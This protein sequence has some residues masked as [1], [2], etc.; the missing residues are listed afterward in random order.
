MQ[1]IRQYMRK[2]SR[3][4]KLVL[5]LIVAILLPYGVSFGQ[6]PT[7]PARG[8]S[9]SSCAVLPFVNRTGHDDP[10][11]P[12]KAA[13]ALTLALEDSDEFLVTSTLDLERA[14]KTTDV[15]LPAS[16]VVQARLGAA[17]R[18]D[19]ILTG[20]IG[21][22]SVNARDGRARCSVEIKMFDVATEAYLD[23]ALATATTAP[24]PGWDGDVTQVIN[25]AMRAAAEMA[26]T[27]MFAKRVQRGSVDIVTDAGDVNI[28]LGIGEGM[29]VGT[30][31]LVMRP[32]WSADL[33]KVVF[34]RV[35]KIR[36]GEV[37]TNMAW[38]K[39][40]EGATPRTGDKLY[41]L[42][43][44][45][46][47]QKQEQRS[48]SVKKTAQIIAAMG[49]LVGIYA[50]GTGS[51]TASSSYITG[52][53]S[54]AA[55]G[56]DSTVILHIQSSNTE[57]ERTHGYVI[58]R[59]ANNP[60]FPLSPMTM[61]DVLQGRRLPSDRYSDDPY[62]TEYRE[63]FEFT[64]TYLVEEGE[65]ED[66][67]V[68]AS[69]NHLPMTPGAKY[70]YCVRRII[71]PL[72]RP[73]YNPPIA[74]QQAE[75]PVEPVLEIDVEGGE[76]LSE[77][78]NHLGPITFFTPPQLSSPANGAPNQDVSNVR[79]TWHVTTGADIYNVELFGPNDPFGRGNL[80]WQ[81]GELRAGAGS[82]VM[83]TSYNV[84]DPAA[85]LTP[86]TRYYWRVGARASGDIAPP[87]NRDLNK[88]G[89]L[90]S[91][92]REFTTA[93][94]PPGPLSAGDDS[95]HKPATRKPGFFGPV[96]RGNVGR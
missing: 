66:A 70:Y 7:Q 93:A 77:A 44:G 69:W 59:A 88:A 84:A 11:L 5:V 89:W 81:S 95:D 35:G 64:F 76:A 17:L 73:G 56:V 28:N 87:F 8:S 55:A 86:D 83:S 37:L 1:A 10:L 30:E 78:S 85:G 15:T 91:G 71:E 74:S 33:E 48:K 57:L 23:G 62:L 43:K 32:T 90:Y 46:V 45:P 19:K 9:V 79:F 3:G 96:K 2:N 20:T 6:G 67:D 38:A 47:Q 63:D 60:Y 31:M 14:M 4:R 72:R 92:M 80:Y 58:Y 39:V 26:V 52:N 12:K 49:L 21:E 16:E 61:I 53:L 22:L 42:Y 75:E 29:V 94:L 25:E 68:E 51:S 40:I 65:E 13:A 82:T 27:D 50:I 36:V 41:R 34:R 18:V 24:M 54:Q